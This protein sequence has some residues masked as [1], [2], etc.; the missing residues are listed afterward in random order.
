MT[1]GAHHAGTA[2]STD[3]DVT[4]RRLEELGW[5]ETPLG[6][7]SLRRRIDPETGR[8]IFEVKL[9]DDF[10]MSSKF[11]DG[12]VELSRIALSR[13]PDRPLDVVVGGLGLGYTAAAVLEDDRVRDL[14]VVDALEPVIE[15]HE[16]GLVPL[17]PSLVSDARCRF[18]LG[19][20][21]A[22]A[23]GGSPWLD[24][25]RPLVDA[26]ILDIDHSPRHVL[27][28]EH[29]PFYEPAGVAQVAAWLRPGGVFALW[30][31]DP[32]DAEYLAVLREALIDCEARVVPFLDN[33]GSRTA[34]NTV[35]VA[36][37]P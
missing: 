30:S 14:A 9:D 6:E 35:Y 21:F 8:D 1:P 25:G 34:K 22:I 13:A 36:S 18:V 17:G 3:S 33:T 27:S 7:V 15:W 10:L 20:F 2:P 32:P 37:K 24:P 19:D 26:V 23:M 29:A 4:R 11:T 31:N 5:R 12:E 28:P 16:E